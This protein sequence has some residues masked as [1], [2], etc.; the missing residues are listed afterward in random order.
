M[1]KNDLEKN[2]MTI[3][4]NTKISTILKQHPDALEAIVSISP[5]F[6]KLRIP[7]L[8]KII[9]SRTTIAMASKIGGC[10][11]NDFFNKLKPL[12]FEIDSMTKEVETEEKDVPDFMK[13]IDPKNVTEL[14][15][16]PVI[17]TGKDP[18][19]LIM[20]SVKQLQEGQVLKIINTFEPTPLMHL[21]GN[22]GFES[23]TDVLSADLFHTYFFKKD[24]GSLKLN[25]EAATDSKDW[26]EILK[27]FDGK[28]VTVD[29]RHL[30]MPLPM[31]TILEALNDLPEEKALYV[32][33]KRI[34]VF[35]IPELEERKFSFRVKEISTSDVHLLIYKD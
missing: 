20:K 4:T 25:T 9:A 18:L 27:R 23:Y 1:Q 3:N 5:K 16:R 15:V 19:N 28:L 12:G 7:L 32:Y 10:N 29:V 8:R 22:Q 13:R 17:E 6:E 30:E 33:H 35:L 11:V 34:P 31:H 21:L 26:D 2:I 24:S 14:D